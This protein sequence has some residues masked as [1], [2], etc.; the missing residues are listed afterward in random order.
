MERFRRW[1]RNHLEPGAIPGPTLA[2]LELE[3]K[4]ELYVA[5]AP[6]WSAGNPAEVGI[7]PIAVWNA[8]LR[9]IREVK[10]LGAELK[11]P[12]LGEPEVFEERE[13]QAACR[14]RIV[15]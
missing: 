1:C 13:V 14:R 15:A 10:R 7:L 12:V 2:R 9:R 8:E 11:L 3:P 4:R 6:R 5:L